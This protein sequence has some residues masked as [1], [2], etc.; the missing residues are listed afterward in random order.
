MTLKAVGLGK[1]VSGSIDKNIIIWNEKR[2]EPEGIHENVHD[3]T[4]YCLDSM[5]EGKFLSG[6]EDCKI[7]MWNNTEVV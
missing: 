5:G 7:K 6:G 2:E 1:F 3:G 4:V